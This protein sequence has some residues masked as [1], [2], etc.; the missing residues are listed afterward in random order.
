[1][2][3]SMGTV[4]A[5]IGSVMAIIDFA[6]SL[7]NG[8]GVPDSAELAYMKQEFKKVN[9]KLDTVLQ[10]TGKLQSGLEFSD[11][12]KDISLVIIHDLHQDIDVIMKSFKTDMRA[13]RQLSPKTTDR[14]A[15]FNARI[16]NSEVETRLDTPKYSYIFLLQIHILYMCIV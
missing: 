10:D 4:G 13:K 16:H 12:T 1:M 3:S 2:F 9:A 7:I 15:E 6:D 14:M 8:G 11:A 5:G